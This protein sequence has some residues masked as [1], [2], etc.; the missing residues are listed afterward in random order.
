MIAGWLH[1]VTNIRERALML[2]LT[3]FV[4]SPGGSFASALTSCWLFAFAVQA[5]R[6]DRPGVP[7]R[8]F[9]DDGHVSAG[10]ASMFAR[11]CRVH[12]D[13]DGGEAIRLRPV[14][15]VSTSR[16]STPEDRV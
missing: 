14:G 5:R 7:G 13:I 9:A 16:H 8:H 15:V 3:C 12:V 6:A 11:A 10:P 2:N 4:R 1:V